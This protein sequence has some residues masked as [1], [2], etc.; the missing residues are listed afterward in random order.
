M[1][2]WKPGQRTL[3]WVWVNLGILT[4]WETWSGGEISTRV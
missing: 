2:M 1:H 4:R 3:S